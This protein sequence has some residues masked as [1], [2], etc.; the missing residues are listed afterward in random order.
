MKKY[1]TFFKIRFLTG[2]QY[3][4][5]AWA[6]VVTQF[7]WGGM[8]LLMFSAFYKNSQNVFPMTLSE[9]SSYIWLQQ[10]LLM[11]FAFWFFDNDILNSISDGN[12]A[13]ELLRPADI[14]KMWFVKNMSVRISRVV[15]RCFPIFIVATFLPA[16]YNISLP[17]SFINGIMFAVSLT[18]GF[19]VLVAISMLIYIS[20]FYTLSSLGIRV[21]SMSLLEFLTGGIIPLPFFPKAWQTVLYLLPSA[22]IRDIPFRIYNGNISGQ[23]MFLSMLNQAAWLLILLLLGEFLMKRALRKVVIQGG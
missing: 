17:S 14:Y 9:L 7:V 2:L 8:T 23:E 20:A 6:G 15:L 11:L 18:L 13:Y 21:L 1:L 4:A 16:P 3:R 19:M 22:Y 12:V 5:A 10:G